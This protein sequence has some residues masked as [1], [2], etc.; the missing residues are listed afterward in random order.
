MQRCDLAGEQR[1]AQD[2]CRACIRSGYQGLPG[3]LTAFRAFGGYHSFPASS[4]SHSVPSPCGPACLPDAA[5]RELKRAFPARHRTSYSVPSPRDTARA[6]ACLPRAAPRELQRFS[7]RG[8]ARGTTRLSR[9]APREVQRAFPAR[10]RASYSVPS[11]RGT[12]R[13]LHELSSV[14]PQGLDSAFPRT[15]QCFFKDFAEP[16]QGLSSAFQ[17]PISAFHKKLAVPF[18]GLSS[19]VTRT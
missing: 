8:T 2:Q 16:F 18:R 9:A 4:H 1:C 6:T 7:P 3:P 15:K 14:F 10:N 13:A 5:P 17:G 11:P 19:A 12:A